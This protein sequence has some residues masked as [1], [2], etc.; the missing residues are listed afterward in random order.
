MFGFLF[1]YVFGFYRSNSVSFSC[2]RLGSIMFGRL[3]DIRWSGW[4][5]R[6]MH[7]GVS[8]LSGVGTITGSLDML[9]F[10]PR[11]SD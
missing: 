11:S 5:I 3:T 2:L 10:E 6:L 8:I 1:L 9:E 7:S 4:T